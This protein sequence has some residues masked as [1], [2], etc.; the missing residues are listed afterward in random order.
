M[1]FVEGL[2]KGG[3]W[4][5]GYAAM[6]TACRPSKRLIMNTNNHANSARSDVLTNGVI[7]YTAG[8][9]DHGWMSLTGITFVSAGTN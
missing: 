9:K 2:I 7:Q 5:K 6:P 4:G 1:C 8:S 3:T